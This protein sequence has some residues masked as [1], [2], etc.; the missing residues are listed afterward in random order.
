MDRELHLS[1]AA[2]MDELVQKVVVKEEY[3]KEEQYDYV[4]GCQDE[5]ENSSSQLQC[6]VTREVH[7]AEDGTYCKEETHFDASGKTAKETDIS[8]EETQPTAVEIEVKIEDDEEHSLLG[9]SKSLLLFN[10]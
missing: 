10:Y 5:E 6:N 4:I 2:E 8:S 3:I 7:I 9:L 1:S